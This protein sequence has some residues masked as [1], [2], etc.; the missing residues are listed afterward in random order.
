MKVTL[1]SKENYDKIMGWFYVQPKDVLRDFPIPKELIVPIDGLPRAQIDELLSDKPE[2]Y[3][4]DYA[5]SLNK[6]YCTRLHFEAPDHF[7]KE[8]HVAFNLYNTQ[9]FDAERYA[10]ELREVTGDNRWCF[11]KAM[12]HH[13]GY[14]KIY[15]FIKEK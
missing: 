15:C 5:E 3:R 12:T 13:S 2:E 9:L 10:K 4:K 7:D 14:G 11:D 1:T 8:W 6:Y